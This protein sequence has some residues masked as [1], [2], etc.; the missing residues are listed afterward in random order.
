VFEAAQQR[1]R[2]PGID[3]NIYK[4]SAIVTADTGFAN[5]ANMQY[6]HEQQI[7]GYIPDN[8]FRNRD[9]KFADQKDKYGKRHQNLPDTVWKDTIAASEFQFEPVKLT[10][11]C[12]FFRPAKPLLM[13]GN[14]K[15]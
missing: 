10:C 8:R 13:E 9:P 12:L 7:N 15:R 6:L 5:E 11:V 14:G 3:D 1:Y 2:T 4:T